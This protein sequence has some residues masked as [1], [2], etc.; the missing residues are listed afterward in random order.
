MSQSKQNY[1]PLLIGAGSL[2]IG[3]LGY[4]AYEFLSKNTKSQSTQQNNQKSY[5]RDQILQTLKSFKKE[6]YTCS[7]QVSA[8]VQ[9][10]KLQSRGAQLD[11]D[12]KEFIFSY[13][14]VVQEMERAEIQ[15]CLKN[16]ITKQELQWNVENLYKNDSEIEEL[17]KQIKLMFDQAALGVPPDP[18]S[19]IPEFLTCDKLL[20]II[21]QIMIST[22]KQLRDFFYNIKQQ[23]GNVNLNDPRILQQMQQIQMSGLKEKILHEYGLDTFEDPSDKILQFATQKYAMENPEFSQKMQIL[24]LKHKKC[25]ETIMVNP[26][27]EEIIE[28][29]FNEDMSQVGLGMGGSMGGFQGFH[30]ARRKQQDQPKLDEKQKV[31]EKVADDENKQEKQNNEENAEQKDQIDE[32]QKE[33]QQEQEQQQEKQ[34]QQQEQQEVQKQEIHE[35]LNKQ[36]QQEVQNP[37][38]EQHQVHENQQQSLYNQNEQDKK[39]NDEKFQDAQ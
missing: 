31:E 20:E 15:A 34:E 19:E 6:L 35:D 7:V 22:T 1:I 27:N 16:N 13:P 25:M 9:Q 23:Y 38:Q 8:M 30:A 5:T 11:F 29:I 33:Q 39:D 32:Q 10:I 12:I 17:Q 14:I 18:K 3:G 4:L 26:D 36:N 37:K 21:Q 2:A 28:K 24:E